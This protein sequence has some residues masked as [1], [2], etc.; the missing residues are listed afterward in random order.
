MST[1]DE[2]FPPKAKGFGEL[3][4]Y[5][6]DRQLV[7]YNMGLGQGSRAAPS[8]WIHLSAVL[9]NVYKQMGLGSITVDPIT[10]N[11]IYPMGVLFV[12]KADFYTS[13]DKSR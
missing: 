1:N 13:T 5:F 10:S 4:T 9:V 11:R 8:S 12:D 2:I 6:G 3:K 7:K